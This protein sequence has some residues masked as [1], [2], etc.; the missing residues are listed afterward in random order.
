MNIKTLIA[1]GGNEWIRSEKHRIY[2]NQIAEI[3]G[4]KC[5]YYKTGNMSKA[6]LNGEHISNSKAR[7]LLS[8]IESGKVWFDVKTGEFAHGMTKNADF[9]GVE[10]GAEIIDKLKSMAADYEA[11]SQQADL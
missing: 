3:Y 2:F 4:L 5:S 9:D 10:I 8:T 11:N 7:K 1:I 6:T